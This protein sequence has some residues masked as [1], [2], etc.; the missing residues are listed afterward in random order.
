M[1]L[2]L[3]KSDSETVKTLATAI[4]TLRKLQDRVE[5]LERKHELSEID[6]GQLYDKV[7]RALGRITARERRDRDGGSDEPTAADEP[8]P[9]ERMSVQELNQ[10]IRDGLVI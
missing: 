4:D 1:S 8:V 9:L 2:F 5:R 7:K 10:R 6:M 3:R